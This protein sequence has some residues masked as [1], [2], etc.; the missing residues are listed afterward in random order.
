[1]A[2][3]AGLR[4]WPG[5][6]RARATPRGRAIGCYFGGSS[7]PLRSGVDHGEPLCPVCGGSGGVRSGSSVGQ[8][9]VIALVSAGAVAVAD[10]VDMGPDGDAKPTGVGSGSM[11]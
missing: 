11:V 4:T 3:P 7:S 10:D 6:Y 1:M 8:V 2:P 9:A 5:R